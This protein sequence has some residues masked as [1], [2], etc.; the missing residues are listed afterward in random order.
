MCNFTNFF[1]NIV[2][3]FSIQDGSENED[4]QSIGE[5]HGFIDAEIEEQRQTAEANRPI[6]EGAIEGGYEYYEFDLGKDFPPD[7]NNCPGWFDGIIPDYKVKFSN[8]P[9]PSGSSSATSTSAK[10]ESTAP[11]PQQVR[12]SL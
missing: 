1:N 7:L 5:F 10:K 9:P 4:D 11:A 8:G 3:F 12:K 2:I 6:F